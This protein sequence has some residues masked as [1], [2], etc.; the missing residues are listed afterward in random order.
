MVER[1]KC[2]D[3]PR[4]FATPI[5]P[6]TWNIHDRDRADKVIAWMVTS[7][8]SGKLMCSWHDKDYWNTDTSDWKAAVERVQHG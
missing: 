6:G 4:Y 2:S 3:M 7:Y 8:L 5:R 1:A